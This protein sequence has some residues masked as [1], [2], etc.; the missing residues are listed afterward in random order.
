MSWKPT[1]LWQIICRSWTTPTF[2]LL[3]LSLIATPS[4]GATP[5]LAVPASEAPQHVTAPWP[6]DAQ[7]EPTGGWELVETGED[8]KA[9]VAMQRT[10]QVAADGTVADEHGALLATLP[11]KSGVQ[12]NRS[13]TL[14]PRA[15]K[16]AAAFSLFRFEDSGEKSVKLWEGERPLFVYNHGV[17]TNEKVVE[18]DRRGARACYVHPVW[19]LNGEVL[20]DDFP[21]DHYHHHGIFWAWPHVLIEGTEYDLWTYNNIQPKF[22]RWLYRQTGPA[23]AVLAVENGWFV[24]DKQVLTERVWL[25]AFRSGEDERSLDIAMVL[26]PGDRPVTLRGAEGKSYGGLTMRFDVWPRRDSAVRAPGH[27]VRLTG[28]SLAAPEDLSNTRL[29]WA[30]LSAQFPGSPQRSGAAVFVHPG[31]P[32]HPP[33]WLTRCY[34]V[35]CVGYPGVD[36]R[37]FEAGVPFRLDYRVWVHKSEVDQERL[38]RHYEAYGAGAKASWKP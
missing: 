19:G 15:A 4:R 31:H 29:P 14:R 5:V 17:I 2:G 25:R 26:I 30:D 22:V 32:D 1:T 8:S 28:D 11:P 13:F 24:G 27:T 16:Q 12:A 7:G 34:G 20:T 3:A 18:Q 36:A 38:G 23:A 21:A 9:P 10:A 6:K 35:L 33:S 37:T